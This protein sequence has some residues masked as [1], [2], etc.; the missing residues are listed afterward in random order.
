MAVLPVVQEEGAW[1]HFV[2]IT[3]NGT[4]FQYLG[5]EVQPEALGTLEQFNLNF[6]FK[7]K[8]YLQRGNHCSVFHLAALKWGHIQAICRDVFAEISSLANN[9]W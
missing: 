5:P 9:S 1:E 6:F 3:F 7:K 8:R 4:K 2:K